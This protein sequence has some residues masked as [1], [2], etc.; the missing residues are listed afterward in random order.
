MIIFN[1]HCDVY[2][3]LLRRSVAGDL[4]KS[5]DRALFGKLNVALDDFIDLKE[6][7]E[8]EEEEEEEK[9][10]AV[11]AVEKVK[12]KEAVAAIVPV[13]EVLLISQLCPRILCKVGSYLTTKAD[14]IISPTLHRSRLLF[15]ILS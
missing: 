2:K 8:E 4:N 14:H 13:Q 10:V 7:G 1:E 15:L 3:T 12:A 9:E 5:I 6:E 11:A